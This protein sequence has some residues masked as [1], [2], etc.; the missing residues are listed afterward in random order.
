[1][2]ITTD[3]FGERFGTVMR[4]LV[5][6]IPFC[7]CHLPSPSTLFLSP[8]ISRHCLLPFTAN[9]IPSWSH[10]LC[11]SRVHVGIRWSRV[12]TVYLFSAGAHCLLLPCLESN[13]SLSYQFALHPSFFIF[14]F[15]SIAPHPYLVSHTLLSSGPIF[16][17]PWSIPSPLAGDIHILY[18]TV[19]CWTA[20]PLFC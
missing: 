19:L 2:D 5:S 1:M 9:R 13:F 3:G 11:I 12:G 8:C 7:Q 14:F 18:S 16:G 10:L 6:S 20:L 15:P 4:G 17:G